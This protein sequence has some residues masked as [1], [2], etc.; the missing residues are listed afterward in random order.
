MDSPKFY[1]RTRPASPNNGQSFAGLS[2]NTVFYN[3]TTA[4]AMM[5]GRFGLAIPALACAGLFARQRN[6]PS[7]V[8]TLSTDS[9]TF[10]IFLTVCLIVF[11]ALSY[12]P[13]LVLGP[14]LEHLM[15][16]I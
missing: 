16:G 15:F 12:L 13:L 7:S 5:A 10:G 9:L 3:I 11:T 2:S 1:L 14:V 6:T 4:L 8:G